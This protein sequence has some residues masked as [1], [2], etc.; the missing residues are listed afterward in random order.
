MSRN[1]MEEESSNRSMPAPSIVRAFAVLL[2]SAS[3]STC[4][5]PQFIVLQEPEFVAV[6]VL[7]NEITLSHDTAN[8]V[9]DFLGYEIYYKFYDPDGADSAFSSDEAAIATVGPGTAVSVLDQRGFNRVFSASDFGQIPTVKVSAVQRSQ[10]FTF[11]IS[12]P[13][14]P[15]STA[16]AAA[17]STSTPPIEQELVR[18]VSLVLTQGEGFAPADLDYTDPD[19]PD[20]DPPPADDTVPMAVVVVAYG[21]DFTNGTFSQVVSTPLVIPELLEIFFE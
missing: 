8:D 15:G 1:S 13:N 14:S 3:F 18:D 11:D 19:V 10:S 4:G 16:A 17:V 20:I 12:F 5:I 2:L 9:D 6:P 7:T 21:V